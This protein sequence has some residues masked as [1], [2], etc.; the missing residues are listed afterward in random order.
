MEEKD[1]KQQFHLLQK[2]VETAGA[3]IEDTR[4]NL[5]A[6]IDALKLEI[7][8]L[9]RFMERYHAD[10]SRRYSELREELMREVDPEWL[11]SERNKIRSGTGEV[12]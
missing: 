8:I 6:T 7:E 1:I 9:K 11:A 10:F 5:V 4:L 2:E 3:R 12:S